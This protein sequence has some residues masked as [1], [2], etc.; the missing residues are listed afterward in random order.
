MARRRFAMRQF[1]VTKHAA[2]KQTEQIHRYDQLQ[3]QGIRIPG[4]QRNQGRHQNEKHPAPIPARMVET[5]NES[6][7]VERQRKNPE[8]GQRGDVLRDMRGHRQQ[9]KCRGCRQR[10]PDQLGAQL[11]RRFR[12]RRRGLRGRFSAGDTHAGNRRITAQTNEQTVEHRPRNRLHAGGDPRLDQKRISQQGQ[13]RSQ[14][15]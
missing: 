14:I 12:G 2:D 6:C 15:R 3:I 5:Q 10:H 9:K 13:Q 11:G 7:Q 4:H 8:E 1:T